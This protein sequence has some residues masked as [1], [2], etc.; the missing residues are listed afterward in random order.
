MA[1]GSLGRRCGSGA[2]GGTGMAAKNSSRVGPGYPQVVILVGATGGSMGAYD[3]VI[4]SM[5]LRWQ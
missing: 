5:G 4:T 1:L 3:N 2:R